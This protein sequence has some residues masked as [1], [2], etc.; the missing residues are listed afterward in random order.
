M[1]GK[2]ATTAMKSKKTKNTAPTEPVRRA[3]GWTEKRWKDDNS[4]QNLLVRMFKFGIESE[5]FDQAV[6]GTLKTRYYLVF[7]SIQLAMDHPTAEYK[8]F[9]VFTNKGAR[10][11][12]ATPGCPQKYIWDSLASQRHQ[13]AVFRWSKLRR[14]DALLL[15]WSLNARLLD[16]RVSALEPISRVFGMSSRMVTGPSRPLA[17]TR[18]QK[19]RSCKKRRGSSSQ[20]WCLWERLMSSAPQCVAML[21]SRLQLPLPSIRSCFTFSVFITHNIC[22][23]AKASGHCGGVEYLRLK[24]VAKEIDRERGEREESTV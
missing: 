16:H 17:S 22:K 23:F 2:P 7:V 1:E 4:A 18:F 12:L 24:A 3:P 20:K 8:N 13:R 15:K 10:E 19:T 6:M 9:D 21:N 14:S 5:L 11:R